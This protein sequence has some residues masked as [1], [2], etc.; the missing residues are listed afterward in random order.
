MNGPED[1]KASEVLPSLPETRLLVTRFH[2]K[3]ILPKRKT[4]GSAG[5]DLYNCGDF[6][7]PAYGKALIGTGLSVRIPDGHYGR[8]ATRSG[9]GWN[10]MVSVGAGVIDSDYTGEVKI[11]LFN[12]SRF[13][14]H[15]IRQYEAIAQLIIE[16]IST[17]EVE[18]VITLPKTER[19]EGGF[20]STDKK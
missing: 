11:M 15:V 16:R 5:Y 4:Q 2:P 20:G 12:H 1:D 7:I 13:D 9:F 17:P 18:E 10:N 19:G 8:I 3:A 14:V 6:T